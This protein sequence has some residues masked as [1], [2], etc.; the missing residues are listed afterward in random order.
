M[1]TAAI[2]GHPASSFPPLLSGMRTL[3]LPT[4]GTKGSKPPA[5]DTRHPPVSQKYLREEHPPAVLASVPPSGSDGG[6]GAQRQIGDAAG[7]SLRRVCQ[8]HGRVEDALLTPA[9]RD[10]EGTRAL[11]VGAG[12]VVA[13]L[14]VTED[15]GPGDG[16]E[17]GGFSAPPRSAVRL[18]P[19]GG[20]EAALLPVLVSGP[21]L[22][23]GGCAA[24]LS[25]PFVGPW[26]RKQEE[27]TRLAADKWSQT[28]ALEPSRACPGPWHRTVVPR[29][30]WPF[31]PAAKW[32]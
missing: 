9:Q 30:P 3:C 1:L 17:L 8:L 12:A 2:P 13:G 18:H 11:L 14:G 28:R 20:R 27:A 25:H 21:R 23:C 19:Q 4:F 22:T 10:L 5:H 24:G 16:P 29:G 31:R 15:Q 26:R 32:G 6:L 7:P